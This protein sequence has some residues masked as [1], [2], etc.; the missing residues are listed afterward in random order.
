[1][2]KEIEEKI[3]EELKR[4]YELAKECRALGYDPKDEVESF[5]AE[6]I[7]ERVEGLLSS[8]YPEIRGK[9]LAERIM[10]LEKIYPSGDLRIAL[11]LAEEASEGKFIQLQS[12]KEA[13]EF[14]VRV[15][16]AYLTLGIVSAPL[17]GIVGVKLKKRLDG[18]EYLACYFSGPIRGAGGTASALTV[19]IADFL[20]KKF[21]LAGYDPTE[22]E[23]ERYV[24]EIE[25]YH[26]EDRMQYFPSREE[27]IFL[28]SHIPIEITGEPTSE[29]EV[30]AYKGLPRVETDRIRGGMCLVL[31]EGI[32]LKAKK[33]L[34]YIKKFGKEFGLEEWEFLEDYLKIQASKYS[35][36]STTQIAPDYRY[37]EEA[38][39]GRPIFSYPS[40][41]NGFRLRYGRSR[42]SG[43]AACGMHPATMVILNSFVAIGS[44][45][46]MERPGKSSAITPCD[47]IEGPVV[48]LKNGDVIRVESMEE[49]EKVVGEVDK[50]LFL[51]DLLISF[52]DFYEQNHVLMP[53]GYTEEWWVQE[54]KRAAQ[55]ASQN[56]EQLVRNPFKVGA[57]EALE[58]SLSL[59]VPLHPKYTYHWEYLGK[60][61]FHYLYTQLE[62]W[63]LIGDN[64]ILKLDEKLKQILEKICLPH[65]VRDG[66]LIV[67]EG[68]VVL[69]TLGI[70]PNW[71]REKIQRELFQFKDAISFLNKVSVLKLRAKVNTTIGA[72]LGRPE[73]AKMRKLRARPHMLFPLGS[74]GG[75]MRSLNEAL[76][77]GYVDVEVPIFICEKCKAKRIYKVC[78][79]CGSRTEQYKICSKCNKY[80]KLKLHCGVE[81]KSFERRRVNLTELMNPVLSRIDCELPE[82]VKGVKGTSSKDKVAERIEKGIL[83]AKYGIYVNKDGTTRF[84]CTEVPITHFKPKEIG[85]SVE[86]LRKLGYEKDIYGNELKSDDQIVEIFPQDLIIPSCEEWE[87][88]NI[89]EELVKVCNFIDELLVKLYRKPPYYKVRRKEDLIGQLVVGLAPHTSVGVVGRIIGF[90]RTQALFAHPMFHAAMRRN[91]DGDETSIILL[92][93]LLLNFSREYLPRKRGGSMDAALVLTTKIRLGEIDK[94]VHNLDIEFSYPL[95][96]Y[97]ATLNRLMP[98]Q[99]N[100]KRLAEKLGS[101]DY[102]GIGFTHDV[103][104]LNYGVLVSQYKKLATMR[105][106]IEKQMQLAEKIVAV[107]PDDVARI[108]VEK[109]FLKD[110]K[111]NLREFSRQEFR[112]VSCNEKYRRIPL[113]GRCEKCGGK[114]I[115]TVAEGVVYKYLESCEELANKYKLPN[116]LLQSLEIIKRRMNSLFGREKQTSLTTYR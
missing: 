14:G 79:V 81:T 51:G 82:L 54:V 39:A 17:E 11:K 73:K 115:L 94:E 28:V 77:R 80:T 67:E 104:D 4:A 15:A 110:I 38:V 66:K 34:G 100:V 95:E 106:K 19:L 63:K 87:E 75:K 23:I 24:V 102:N 58:V 86:M 35:Q 47:Q 10:E 21:N 65:K 97:E 74:S 61:D 42:I 29:R 30:V 59:N 105:E 88:A 55:G 85:V 60:E 6:D 101:N 99:V 50:I 112:C 16:L 83:R 84:D 52:G 116:Y 109:H 41:P 93:D 13:I 25:D 5:L 91:C 76:K 64:L 90:S 53:S 12:V 44:Q 31:C 32:A 68:K 113:S 108:L 107:N 72:R 8:L 78:E 37:I 40:A 20:R 26:S 49:A 92:L 71:E 89:A 1:M 22:K 111:G 98:A 18:K 43:L 114:I 9:G 57:N 48:R 45:L 69:Y 36:E 62:N 33:L 56:Y 3:K 96:F 7:G 46:R 70:L 27:I 2:M 103:S